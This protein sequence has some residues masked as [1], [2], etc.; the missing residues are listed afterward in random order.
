MPLI[1]KQQR[2]GE[3]SW[4]YIAGEETAATSVDALI[5]EP[6]DLLVDWTLWLQHRQQ[7]LQRGGRLGVKIDGDLDLA[8]L[9]PDLDKLALVAVNFPS[10][11]DGRGFSQARLLRQSYGFKGELRAVGD[12]TWDRLRFMHRCGFDSFDIAEDR[13]SDAMFRAFSEISVSLQGAV[14]DPRPLYR[15]QP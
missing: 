12:V 7:L 1:T 5:A 3:D 8:E 11:A 13:Y 6:G 4:N 14:D 15:Q 9:A 2:V 10:F